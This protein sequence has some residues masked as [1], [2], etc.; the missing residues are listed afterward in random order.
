MTDK[1]IG[2]SPDYRPISWIKVE[3]DQKYFENTLKMKY[4]DELEKKLEK[5]KKC[6]EKE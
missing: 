2:Y 3:R 1:L 4:I 5:E 6:Q